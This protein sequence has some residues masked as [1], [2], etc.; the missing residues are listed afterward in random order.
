[1]IEQVFEQLGLVVLERGWLS[2]NNIVFHATPHSAAAVVDTGYQSH[3]AQTLS[4]LQAALRGQPLGCIVNTHLHSDH[5]G[6]NAMLQGLWEAETWVP[7]PLVDVVQRWDESVLTYRGTDQRCER[8]RADRALV[9][10]QSLRLG[11]FDWQIVPAPGHDPDAVMLFEP[12]SRVLITA[13]AL[14]ENRL[15]I[16]FPE[17]AGAPGFAEARRALDTVES[18]QPSI[19]IPGHGGPFTNV[20]SALAASRER[21]TQ[22]EAAPEKHLR[23]AERALTMFHMLEQR[24]QTREALIGWLAATPIFQTAL[25]RLGIE[26][27][28]AR[29]ERAAQ[30]VARL[31]ADGQLQL[32]AAGREICLPH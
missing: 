23:L 32:T 24:Q 16:I 1:M 2:S 18:L 19:V 25:Q 22:F 8:F 29:D 20:A 15:A 14:W 12:Q 6:G 7:E 11:S 31:V 3:T 30:I 10:G 28:D 13:D 17:L 21:I 9:A 5:C 26:S 4:L 27:A